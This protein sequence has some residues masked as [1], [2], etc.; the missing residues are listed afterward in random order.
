VSNQADR[1]RELIEEVAAGELDAGGHELV[2]VLRAI[3]DLDLAQSRALGALFDAVS[4][5]G[6]AI[7]A[8]SNRIEGAIQQGVALAE[9][10]ATGS[11][12]EDAKVELREVIAEATATPFDPE[13]TQ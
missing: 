5:H 11:D 4:D 13:R 2:P 8:L 10:M 12:L 1:I 6:D 3:G 9:V 7:L